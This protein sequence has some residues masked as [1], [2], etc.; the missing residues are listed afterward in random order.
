MI[1]KDMFTVGMDFAQ[2]FTNIVGL[3]SGDPALEGTMSFEKFARSLSKVAHWMAVIIDFASHFA[4][5]LAGAFLGFQIGGPMGAL[6]G[7]GVGGFTD[8]IRSTY[9]TGGG[10]SGTSSLGTAAM[11]GDSDI[12][13]VVGAVASVE[14]GGHQTNRAGGTLTSS[15]GALGIMQLMP[16]TA[17]QL[18]VN[19]Y[20]AAEN[21]AGGK[22]Y[23][24]QL[25]SKYG[26]WH[27]ALG[28]YN[29]GPGH[30]DRA[31]RSHTAFPREVE[32]YISSVQGHYA[33]G[34][35]PISIGQ[36]NI[37][38]PNATPDQ[39]AQAVSDGISR[40]EQLASASQLNEL[41]PAY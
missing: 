40:R 29:W 8:L 24:E 33:R 2:L 37:M 41:K 5:T 17:W 14:S 21:V 38:Q 3:I 6:I 18:G 39:I 35:N 26:N 30:V 32:G 9:H 12:S 1:L 13:R 36:I 19:P 27:D 16:G 4:G 11:T 34:D 31:L 20:N 23:L 28:A 25:H 7:A 22:M 15:T 10:D